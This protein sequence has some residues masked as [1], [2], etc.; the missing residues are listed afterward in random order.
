MAFVCTCTLSSN[1]RIEC[2]IFWIKTHNLLAFDKWNAR[3]QKER[4][5]GMNWTQHILP[6]CRTEASIHRRTAP[7]TRNIQLNKVFHLCTYL[8][9]DIYTGIK[10]INIWTHIWT[11]RAHINTHQYA[12]HIHCAYVCAL[13]FRHHQFWSRKATLNGFWSFHFYSTYTRTKCVEHNE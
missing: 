1:V 10:L 4:L 11:G 6:N 9:Y 7:L 2:K 3:C 12:M 13:R 8:R 5:L